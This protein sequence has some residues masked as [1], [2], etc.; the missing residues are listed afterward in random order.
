MKKA[1]GKRKETAT[2]KRKAEAEE[3]EPVE[4]VRRSGR[5]KE[6]KETAVDLRGDEDEP[7]AKWGKRGESSTGSRLSSVKSDPKLVFD[8]A[9]KELRRAVGELCAAP[10]THGIGS[11]HVT[12]WPA[13]LWQAERFMWQAT[14][15]AG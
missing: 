8:L 13:C 5:S 14:G 12:V 3:K 7:T 11:K 15:I 1:A 10:T 4:T 2:S 9:V 6:D